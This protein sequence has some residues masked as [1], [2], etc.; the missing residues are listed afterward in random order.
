MQK[1]ADTEVKNFAEYKKK[2]A[3]VKRYLTGTCDKIVLVH[4]MTLNS[5]KDIYDK[6]K[7]L[8]D[9]DNEQEKCLLFNKF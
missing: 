4:L 1:P 3:K 2:D 6:L 9:R 5:G 7:S 8:F